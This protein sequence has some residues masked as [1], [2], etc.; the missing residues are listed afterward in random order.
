M[1]QSAINVMYS[2]KKMCVSFQAVGPFEAQASVTLW[3][4]RRVKMTL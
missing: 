2:S 3:L 4:W 1:L